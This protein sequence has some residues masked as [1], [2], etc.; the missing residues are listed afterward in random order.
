MQKWKARP[1]SLN[2]AAYHDL[3]TVSAW[4]TFAKNMHNLISNL[5]K[6]SDFFNHSFQ[7]Y[8][9]MDTLANHSKLIA[10][11]KIG[12]TYENRS[13]YVLKVNRWYAYLHTTI[14]FV[15]YL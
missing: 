6:T 10:K 1:K 14:W 4:L 7:I 12:S 11:V 2:F 8:N 15:I 5:K 9:F 13:M 3:E